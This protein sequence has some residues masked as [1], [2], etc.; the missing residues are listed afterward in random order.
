[1]GLQHLAFCFKD[2]ERCTGF[3]FLGIQKKQNRESYTR[4]GK[5]VGSSMNSK[6][7]KVIR[8][9]PTSLKNSTVLVS[10]TEINQH[11]GK[12]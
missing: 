11:I 1:M 5:R 3:S 6:N 2:I 12:K 4:E 8:I 9:R 7:F 10:K